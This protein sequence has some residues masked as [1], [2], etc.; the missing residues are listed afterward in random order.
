MLPYFPQRDLLSENKDSCL[1]SVSPSTRSLHVF[2]HSK[3]HVSDSSGARKW[4]MYVL[5]SHQKCK[6]VAPSGF[7]CLC[8]C[9]GPTEGSVR[10]AEPDLVVRFGAPREPDP[11]QW[12]RL[13]GTG[14]VT[15][16]C[17][18]FP[19]LKTFVKRSSSYLLLFCVC[20]FCCSMLQSSSRYRDTP[21]SAR[22]QQL[23]SRRCCLPCSLASRNCECT[24]RVP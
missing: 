2:P 11:G 8:L 7:M 9:V 23:K 6:C 22:V 17:E 21:W 3:E 13:A 19:C 4:I 24:F 1:C 14:M 15:C 12:N 5:M 18:A 16:V 10:P 20:L